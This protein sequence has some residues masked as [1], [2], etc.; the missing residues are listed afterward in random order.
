M[1][2]EL[3]SNANLF[4]GGRSGK[5]Q[6]HRNCCARLAL[7]V[8]GALRSVRRRRRRAA[9]QGRVRGV[10]ERETHTDRERDTHRQTERQTYRQETA[11]DALLLVSARSSSRSWSPRR[12]TRP[13]STVGFG[14]TAAL[15]AVP[16]CR[17]AALSHCRIAALHDR[18]STS[19]QIC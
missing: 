3:E 18:S 14:R 15:H 5:L 7:A 10:C 6:T 1:Q 8:G 19:Y 12:A 13:S 17:P 2:S 16:H 11:I 4:V 9:R